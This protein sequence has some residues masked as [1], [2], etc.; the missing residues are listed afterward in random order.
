MN[1]VFSVWKPPAITSFDIVR[2]I[3][4]LN[5]S[6]KVGHC[7]TLDPFAEGVVVICTGSETSN[8]SYYMEKKKKYLAKIIFGKETDTLD[9]TGQVIKQANKKII[10]TDVF[11]NILN[12]FIGDILQVPPYFSAKKINNVKLYDL[13]RKNIFVR[14][15][16]VKVTV[17]D[18][19]A[20]E[21]SQDYAIIEVFCSKGTYIRCLARDIAYNLDTYGYLESLQRLS[22]GSFNEKNSIKY[23]D[24]DKCK[25]KN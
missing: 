24:L 4:S 13:A 25:F 11:D 18:I 16:P 23:E 12:N 3:K 6:N 20:I 1:N 9:L 8:S 10:N 15:K 2:K 5:I 22:V 19:K 14:L 17:Y 21:V 7:G